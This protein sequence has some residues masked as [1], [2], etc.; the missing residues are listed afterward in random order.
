[1]TQVVRWR[2]PSPTDKPRATGVPVEASGAARSLPPALVQYALRR[3]NRLGVGLDEVLIAGG[4]VAADAL[5]REAAREL[6]IAFQPLDDPQFPTPARRDGQ[7]AVAVLRSGVMR[8][9]EGHLVIAARGLALRRLAATLDGRPALRRR[10]SLTTPER[11]AAFIRQRFA[12]ELGWR[13]AYQ[14][15]DRH[16]RL[17]AGTLT[18]SRWAFAIAVLAVAALFLVVNTASFIGSWVLPGLVAI[19]LVGSATL[20]LAACTMPPQP[21]P[22]PARD[23]RSLPDYSLI[24]PLY[25]EARVVPQLIDALDALDY[26]GE[27][28]QVLFVVEPDDAST[29]A[30]LALHASRPGFEII[31]APDVGP[32]TKPKAMNAALPFARGTVVGIYDAEDVP[33][34][35]QLRQVCTIL[36]ARGN[37]RIGC[38]QARLVIDNLADGWITRQFAAEYAAYF[39]VVLPML[40][41]CR[42]PLPLGGTSNH[43]RRA[44]LDAVGGWD[45]FNVTEDADL[46]VRLARAGWD[47]AVIA[48]ATDEE[49]PSRSGTWMRQRTRWYKGW[50]QTLLVHARHP[51]LLA[52][53]AGWPGTLTLLFLLGSGTAAALLHPVMVA[54][55]LLVPVM[56]PPA[57]PSLTA[58][59]LDAVW[60]CVLLTGL[61]GAVLSTVLG[62]RRRRAPGI[63]RVLALM[64]FYW[65]MTAAAAWRALF[66]LVRAPYR[67]EKTD[68][69]LAR[70]S[71]RHPR[72]RPVVRLRGSGAARQRPH[73]AA[74][75]D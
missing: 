57:S 14:L 9:P 26:P 72:L 75:S 45:P 19:M 58:S 51:L 48:S 43:F 18:L 65:L 10:V 35:L 68:H 12:A 49:A 2:S 53:G 66:Q 29:A 74:A 44:A 67:W 7:D 13:A 23:D 1:M 36:M 28:L 54:S 24:V 8:M 50:M 11:L 21:P 17:S 20:K 22:R 32:Q 27:K 16:P 73:P 42:L 6:G 38:V 41:R 56:E 40:G 33:D 59:L 25:R 70:T 69:G 62:M 30:A 31:V 47:T 3:A 39:D 46:G 37:Q 4:H 34:P 63:A 60:A 71:R 52:R 5:A 15:R 61:S 64:P 55:L